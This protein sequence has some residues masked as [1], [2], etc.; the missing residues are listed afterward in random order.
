MVF[1][2]TKNSCL[3]CLYQQ[4]FGGDWQQFDRV[5]KDIVGRLVSVGG[6]GDVNH[7]AQ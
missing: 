2:V 3:Y 1:F 4:D 5:C 6:A 7:D